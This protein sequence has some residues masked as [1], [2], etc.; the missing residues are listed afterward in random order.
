MPPSMTLR[1]VR[2]PRPR[3]RTSASASSNPT[4]VKTA[5]ARSELEDVPPDPGT[6]LAGTLVGLPLIAHAFGF[7]G[8]HLVGR[9]VGGLH[10]DAFGLAAYTKFV[11]RR[12]AVFGVD[13][14][15]LLVVAACGLVRIGLRLGGLRSLR[16]R[17]LRKDGGGRRGAGQHQRNKPGVANEEQGGGHERDCRS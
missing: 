4:S 15:D 13:A 6:V 5:T 10:D 14:L 12:V 17:V 9:P 11:D 1:A 7:V 2:A 16:L 8:H 3:R